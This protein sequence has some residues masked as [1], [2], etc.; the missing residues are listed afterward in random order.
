MP[1]DLKRLVYGKSSMRKVVFVLFPNVHL[2]DLAGP[3]QV[4]HE[5]NAYQYSYELEF[6]SP[7]DQVETA[8]G[9]MFASLKHYTDIEIH[10]ETFIMIPGVQKDYLLNSVY[11]QHKI[12]FFEWLRNHH[13]QGIMVCS[14]CTGAF[15]LADAGILDNLSCTSHW[16]I[17][18]WLHQQFPKLTVLDDCLFVKDRN[19]FTS[20]GIA[21][22]IDMA[23][24]I[25][26]DHYGPLAASKVAREM[27]IYIR[28]NGSTPQR[29]VYL[30]YRTHLNEKV[31]EV[32]DWLI[33]NIQKRFTLDELADYVHMSSRNLTRVFKRE[34]GITINEFITKLR[35][36]LAQKILKSSDMSIP[37]V[38]E[39]CGFS[40]ERQFRRVWGQQSD[41]S[42]FEWRTL[43]QISE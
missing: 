7:L 8:Q 9:L 3:V 34:T 39:E 23:L 42:P 20:A 32:Q 30:N 2:L 43:K 4:F 29:S 1:L 25:V 28:R 26:E 33:A 12:P 14:I 19:V 18:Q 41:V 10:E 16:S 13:Q 15:I 17:L 5:A 38:A 6:C 11:N 36:E 35:L 21:S 24:Y 37:Q 40:S 31:H 22:G 27:V